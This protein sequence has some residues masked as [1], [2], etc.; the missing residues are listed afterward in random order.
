VSYDPYAYDDTYEDDYETTLTPEQQMWAMQQ[1]VLGGGV[2][3][4]DMSGIAGLPQLDTKGREQPYDLGLA[5]Q[6]LNYGQDI[7]T[8]MTNPFIQYM[9]GPGAYAPGS[10]DPVYDEKRLDLLQGRQLEMMRQSG[11]IR[12]LLADFI[13]GNPDENR[14]PMDSSQAAARVRAMIQNSTGDDPEIENLKGELLPLTDQNGIVSDKPDFSVI[15]KMA[16]EIYKPYVAEQAM[17]QQPDVRVLEDGRVVQVTQRDSPTMEF[18]KKAGLPDPRAQY[19]LEFALQNDPTL[20]TLMQTQA[21]SQSER[22]M[23]RKEYDDRLKRI[24]KRRDQSEADNAEMEKYKAATQAAM[25]DYFGQLG[26]RRGE[27]EWKGTPAEIEVPDMPSSGFGAGFGMPAVRAAQGVEQPQAPITQGWK[28][29]P[30]QGERPDLNLPSRPRTGVQYSMMEQLLGKPQRDKRQALAD[31]AVPD[32]MLRMLNLNK[33][34]RLEGKGTQAAW[35]YAMKLA[36]VI[37]AGR[38]GQTPASDAIAARLAPLRAMGAI[39]Y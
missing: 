7:G 10:L 3:P 6:R 9:G 18:L 35:E 21:T 17:L 28:T 26:R 38:R 2:A 32:A 23:I 29:R 27:P 16:D 25:S 5:A 8:S 20:M 1:L 4:Q 14:P 24:Q 37:N 31:E 13:L 19:D 15:N 39:G 33:R 34:H 36:P 12:G 30:I 22:D 11:G